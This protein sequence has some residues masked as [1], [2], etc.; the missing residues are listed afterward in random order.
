M[1]CVEKYP[2]FGGRFLGHSKVSLMQTCLI[3]GVPFKRDS[4]A[5]CSVCSCNGYSANI[6]FHNL[7]LTV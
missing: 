4:A 6:L 2:H 5:L 7:S 3:S 1:S